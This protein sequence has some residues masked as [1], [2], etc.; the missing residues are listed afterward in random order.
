MHKTKYINEC[1]AVGYT[2]TALRLIN[3]NMEERFDRIEAILQTM[4][5]PVIT[6]KELSDMAVKA[7]RDEQY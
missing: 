1:L 5:R 7:V 2:D 4:Q 3:E 6:E